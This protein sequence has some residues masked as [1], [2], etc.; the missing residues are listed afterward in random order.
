MYDSPPADEMGRIH[1]LTQQKR[2]LG[3]VP[4]DLAVRTGALYHPSRDL[5]ATLSVESGNFPL[6]LEQLTDVLPNRLCAI[7]DGIHRTVTTI[8]FIAAPAG[9]GAGR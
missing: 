9:A 2:H 7:N 3:K 1:G 8:L 6:S 5:K 4:F